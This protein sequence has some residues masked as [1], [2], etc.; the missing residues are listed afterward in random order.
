MATQRHVG[1][2]SLGRLQAAK[3]DTEGSET[4]LFDDLDYAAATGAIALAV[5][6]VAV[7]SD[8]DVITSKLRGSILPLTPA[9][10]F[11]AIGMVQALNVLPRLFF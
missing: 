5:V 4:A 7:P 9:T 8:I 2:H 6:T 1:D 11:F 3:A 10:I